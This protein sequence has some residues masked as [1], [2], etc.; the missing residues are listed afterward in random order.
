MDILQQA[1]DFLKQNWHIKRG[2]FPYKKYRKCPYRKKAN[3]VK[4]VNVMPVMGNREEKT[5]GHEL[6]NC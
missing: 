5:T 1:I 6:K 4:L 2:H 3:C